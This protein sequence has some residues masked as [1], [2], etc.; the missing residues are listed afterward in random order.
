VNIISVKTDEK[1]L[2]RFFKNVATWKSWF[3]FD[4]AI[5]GLPL[6]QRELALYRHCTGRKNPPEKPFKEVYCIVGR[7]GGKSWTISTIAVYLAFFRDYSK[8]LAA[9]EMGTI[10]IVAV[11]QIQARII[12]RYIKAIIN[13]IPMLKAKVIKERAMDLELSNRVQVMIRT[14]S[15]ASVRG[16]TLVGAILEEV[17]FWRVAGVNPDHEV[18]TALRPGLATIPGSMLLAISSPYGRQGILY[19][20]Y[21]DHF[22]SDNPDI[23]VFRGKTRLMNPTI[24]QEIID[25]EFEKDPVAAASEW[26]HDFRKDLESFLPV[27]WI[28]KAIVPDRFELPP[29][30]GFSYRA[31]TDPSGGAPGGDAFTLSIGHRDGETL[32]QD[33]LRV[34]KPPFNPQTTVKEYA[35]LL[36]NYRIATVEGDRYA[37]EWVAQAF[38][39]EGITYKQSKKTKSDLY[40]EFEPLL[41]QGRVELLDNKILFNE[42]R[43]LERRTGRSGKDSVDRAPRQHDDSANSTAGLMVSLVE[44]SS[45]FRYA[46]IGPDTYQSKEASEPHCF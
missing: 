14:C 8:Y 38:Q 4:K 19:E 41:A 39:A 17:S 23:L 12:L 13:E 33:V 43:S 40:L 31:F 25:R 30:Q 37:G 2:G 6:D 3:V 42:L 15:L 36:K 5:F 46:F 20:A 11:D 21:R 24:A 28:E 32:V 27:E 29:V 45:T 10:L 1:L 16:Y 26:G 9:G 44:P 7:R 34:T 18:L 35:S 22:G